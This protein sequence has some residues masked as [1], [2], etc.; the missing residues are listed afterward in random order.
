[1]EGGPNPRRGPSGVSGALPGV[2][3]CWAFAESGRSKAI[4]AAVLA[5]ANAFMAGHPAVSSGVSERAVKLLGR[6]IGHLWP[7][8]WSSL[9]RSQRDEIFCSDRRAPAPCKD[10]PFLGCLLTGPAALARGWAGPAFLGCGLHSQKRV[11]QYVQR[12]MP[13]RRPNRSGVTERTWRPRQ[14]LR[15]ARRWCREPS[16]KPVPARQRLRFRLR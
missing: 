1:M 14:Q 9:P 12:R 10:L 11:L 16:R 3:T 2:P 4:A 5:M 6:G 8:G 13:R 15:R 7:W